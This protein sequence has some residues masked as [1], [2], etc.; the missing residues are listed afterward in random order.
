MKHINLLFIIL[1]LPVFMTA[2][3]T[4]KFSKDNS[5]ATL[6]TKKINNK[7]YFNVYELNKIF[8]ASVRENIIDQR[9]KITVYNRQIIGL[10]NSDYIQAGS[11]IFRLADPIIM[12]NGKIFLPEEFLSGVLAKL[13]GKLI[14]VKGNII[15][16]KS[17][18]NQLLQK[19]V[20]DPG[21]GGKDPGAVG[22]KKN[23]EKDVVLSIAK[24]LK[25]KLEK[26]LGVEVLLTRSKD[27][28]MSLQNRTKFAN[29]ENADLF[30]SIHCNAGKSRKS[31]GIEVYYLSTAK[32]NEAR[33]VEALENSVVFE[34]EG[35]QDAVKQYDDLSFI[36]MDM[37]QTEQLEESSSLA[38]SLQESLVSQT[39]SKNRG[40]KQA[41]FYVL[42]GA[43]MP[44]VLIETGFISNPSE[45]K[46]L[47]S[48]KHQNKIANAILK[49]VK[50]F[51]YKYDHIR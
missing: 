17:P 48:P 2:D 10:L 3:I 33:A 20:I 49:S 34:Y 45:E 42:K 47:I 27:E 25:P 1:L 7:V 41:G 23:F 16:A 28:F 15:S 35:G 36:L 43:F 6:L 31:K 38:L 21:H 11:D 8:H 46:K 50:K 32:T 29:S 5:A 51:K 26:E 18:E 30:I 40:V 19:I 4:I 13:P 12:D 44:A 39:G 37:A 9:I 14:E 22:Y 24:I